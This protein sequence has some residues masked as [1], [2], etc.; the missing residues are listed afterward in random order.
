MVRALLTMGTAGL[1]AG[2]AG[3]SPRAETDGAADGRLNVVT[4]LFPYYD[5]ARQIGGEE[6][7][8]SLVVP[9]GMD[10]HAFEP[11]PADMRMIQEADIIFCN[12]GEMENW[13]EQVLAS[14]DTSDIQVVTMMDFVDAVEEEI[15][16]G[17]EDSGHGHEHG[18]ADDWDAD[19]ADGWDAD[20]ADDW[21]ADDADGGH[22]HDHEHELDE[23]IWTSPRTAQVFARVIGD[24]LAG[25]DP[26][27]AALYGERT[28][29]YIGQLSALDREFEELT[30]G[31]RRHMMVVA[32][33]FPFRYL[34]DD[35]GLEY[36]AAFSG[37]SSDSEPSAKTIAYLIDL[38]RE[39]EIPVVYYLELKTPRVAEIIGEETGAEPLLLHSCHNVTRREF[40]SG[41]TYLQLMEQNV[42]N[43]RKG[44]N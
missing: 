8:L 43:L 1:L 16:E 4:S 44:L 15:V 9:A 35:Y 19:D 5:F 34:A 10:S 7:D 37:C 17:M 30:A 26:G 18:D 2:C 36:R 11:T 14:L 39:Q 40:E 13:L 29:A 42:E 23:H 38:V 25:A 27:H 6:I 20:G 12:G 33:K 3:C 28:E 24:A 21:D 41:V 22:D 31:S 32:D